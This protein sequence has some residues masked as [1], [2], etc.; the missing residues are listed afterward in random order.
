METLKVL[1]FNWRCWLNPAMGGAEVFTYENAKR[2]V[3][4]GHEV[5]LFTSKFPN[6]ERDEVVDGVRIVRAGG[7]YSVYWKAKKYYRKYFC[8]EGYDVVVDEIN[9]RPFLTPKFVYN[10]EKIIALIHQL[11]REYWFYETPFP[12]N[13]IGYYYLENRWLKSYVNI[14]TV[15]V[16]ESTKQDLMHL[17]FRRVFVVSEGLNFDPLDKAPEKK[18]HPVIVYVG[19]LKK[20]KRPDHAIK[21]FKMI[22]GKISE[23]ELWVIGDGYFRKDLEKISFDG[24]KFFGNLSNGKRRKFVSKTWVMANPSVREGFGLNVIEAN[25][26]GVPCVAYDVPGLRDSIQNCETG[27]LVKSGDAQAL[28]EGLF[29]TLE[30]EEFREKLSENA[31][32]YS[33]DFSWDKTAD[34]FMKII[35]DMMHE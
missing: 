2:W 5:I 16:S 22:K 6:C 27:L 7:K 35:K 15:T 14:P 13:Y 8:R 32:E 23:A 30:D 17:E 25:A 18:E 26:L 29:K 21:A 28:A 20:A 19:R 34:D 12:I 33:K 24:V 1:V 9:T 10:G 11:A 4:A 31:L 3:K